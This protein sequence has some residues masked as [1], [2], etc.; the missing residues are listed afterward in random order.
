MDSRRDFFKTTFWFFAALPA[1]ILSAITLGAAFSP[2][3][4]KAGP[5]SQGVDLGDI[6]R[7]PDNVPQARMVEVL[8]LDGW[9]Q[10]RVPR[11]VFIVKNGAK[12]KVLSPVCTH[13]GCQVDWEEGD[14]RFH[15]P[16]HGGQYNLNGDVV[17]GP[18]PRS[19]EEIRTEIR[20]NKLVIRPV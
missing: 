13:L 16:C 17:A 11:K 12:V 19:L 4:R 15:C 2:V 18:P 14:K 10:Q 5:L 3:L 6:S 7:I 1:G 9:N 20:D 8:R